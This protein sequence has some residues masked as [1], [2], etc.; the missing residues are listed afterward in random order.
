[1]VSVRTLETEYAKGWLAASLGVERWRN[2]WSAADLAQQIA[3]QTGWDTW[4][5]SH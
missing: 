4:K 5:L 3:W 2:P 1:M